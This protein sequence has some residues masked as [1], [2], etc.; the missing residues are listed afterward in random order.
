M[1]LL[2]VRQIELRRI[3]EC[4]KIQKIDNC[5]NELVRN[6]TQKSFAKINKGDCYSNCNK[7]YNKC[8][9]V[10]TEMI[11]PCKNAYSKCYD[12]CI[13]VKVAAYG[14]EDK[15]KNR[16]DADNIMC[17]QIIESIYEKFICNQALRT[18]RNRYHCYRPKV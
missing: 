15:C 9:E 10:N 14:T 4:R 13:I 8:V 2:F 12:D 16:C 18:C 5:I 17:N 11:F 6:H 7:N 3:Y 1:I